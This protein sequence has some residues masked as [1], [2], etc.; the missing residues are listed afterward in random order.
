MKIA[1]LT[2]P[3]INNYG[4]ILQAYALQIVLKKLGHEVIT[5]DR[6]T[7][8]RSVFRR[9]LSTCK[10]KLLTFKN[11]NKIIYYKKKNEKNINININKFIKENIILSEKINSN[12][13][14][15]LFFSKKKYDAI[16]IGSDQTWRPKYSP[17]IYN[18]YLDFL[19][20]KNTKRISYAASFGVDN[21]EYNETDTIKC[22]QLIKK[23][24]SVSV[25]ENSGVKL[26]Q[27]H[28]NIDAKHVL[29]P[30]LLLKPEEYIDILKIESSPLKTKKIFSYILNTNKNK[31]NIINLI[32][33]ELNLEI[34]KIEPNYLLENKIKNYSHPSIEDWIKSFHEAEFIVTDS[35]HGCVFSILFNKPFLAISNPSRGLTRFKSLLNTFKLEHR[36]ISDQEKINNTIITEPIDWSSIN[37]ILDQKREQSIKFI[38]N[39][40]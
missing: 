23:F 22:K 21:W 26:C 9:F 31:E 15:D 4:G 10:L 17:N 27:E 1:I 11:K 2:Q 40:L 6:Q 20:D 34:F 35:F 33:N 24:D 37:S 30:T 36:L 13:K 28:F 25:R 8:K 32:S 29:D 7:N 14:M 38:T 12:K 16:I 18:F 39:S 19:K 3:L 5:I